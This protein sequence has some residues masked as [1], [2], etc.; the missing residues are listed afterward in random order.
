MQDSTPEEI[1]E[2][3]GTVLEISEELIDEIQAQRD[4]ASAESGDLQI[5]NTEISPVRF[6]EDIKGLY[7]SHEVARGKNIEIEKADVAAIFTDRIQLRRVVGNMLKNALEAIKPGE[8]VRIGGAKVAD[9]TG[10]YRFWVRNPGWIPRDIQLQL[11]QRSF[12]TKGQNRGLGTY[13]IKLLG[14]KYLNGKV[15]FA[16]SQEKGTVFWLWL[17]DLQE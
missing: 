9:D 2:L 6:L 14:E 1:N 8:V 5:K 7:S 3:S 15:G 13:S 11:F 17:P 16:S 12:S 4:L 10:G